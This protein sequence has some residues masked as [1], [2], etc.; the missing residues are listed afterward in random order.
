MSRKNLSGYVSTYRNLVQVGDIQ[1]AYERL[2]KY[3]LRLRTVFSKHLSPDYAVGKVLQGYMD[4]TYFYLSD[5]YLKRHKLKLGLVFNHAEANFEFWLLGQTKDVQEKY[6]ELLKG[7]PWV[8]SPTMP[9]YSVFEVT[10]IDTPDFDDLDALTA[11]LETQFKRI[12]QEVISAV[13]QVSD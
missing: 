8:R 3:V 13:K 7:S 9:Q 6:W 4:Y 2:V 11:Q 10:L 5:N 12:S 1:I